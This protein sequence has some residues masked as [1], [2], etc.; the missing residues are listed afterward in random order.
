MWLLW[1]LL[2]SAD[3][4]PFISTI[5]PPICSYRDPLPNSNVGGYIQCQHN[6]MPLILPYEQDLLPEATL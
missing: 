2:K 4:F 1:T 6:Y 5:I 3:V